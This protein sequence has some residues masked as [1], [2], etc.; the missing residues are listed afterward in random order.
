[1][2]VLDLSPLNEYD[3][4]KS[5]AIQVEITKKSIFSVAI[6]RTSPHEPALKSEMQPNILN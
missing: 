2:F 6:F 4:K 1:M 5:L 3:S